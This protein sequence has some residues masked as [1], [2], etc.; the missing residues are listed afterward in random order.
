[1][2]GIDT[3]GRKRVRL[4]D[5]AN[6]VGVSRGA[7]GRVLLGSGSNIGVSEETASRIRQV[8]ARLNY[9]P[10]QVA[11]Q[12]S[13][14]SSRLIGAVIFQAVS[15]SRADRLL[16]FEAV[17]RQRGYRVVI[18]QLDLTQGDLEAYLEDFAMRGVEA[19]VY[20][21]TSHSAVA[22]LAH[23]PKLV[24]SIRLPGKDIC[25]VQMDRAAASRMAV[26]HLFQR[27]HRRIG[28]A[29][30]QRVA[31]CLVEDD[32][33]TGYE[34][35]IA[36]CGLDDGVDRISCILT[37]DPTAAQDLRADKIIRELVVDK[38]CDAILFTRDWWAALGI[39]ALKRLG[40]RVPQDVAVVG[41]DNR[42]FCTLID[43]ELTTID[44]RH[45][46]CAEA[47]MDMVI[48]LVENRSI[49]RNERGVMV[50]PE[51]VIRQST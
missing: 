9:Q 24:S 26:E 19:F 50:P 7:V 1:M 40:Y 46:A 4:V 45:V 23:L 48:R 44:H 15:A 32:K 20:L 34:Q 8:A 38:G 6:E 30:A 28:L 29:E 10:N 31:G 39:K 22:R 41:F 14:K 47:M 5:I 3:T 51:L 33:R 12:L 25:F 49:P 27:G 35:A 36:A 2:S 11:Q 17:A 37:D 16:S 18:G 13:G 42:D 21:D 43:P